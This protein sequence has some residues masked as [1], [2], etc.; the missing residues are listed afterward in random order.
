VKFVKLC[1]K[2]SEN[3]ENVSFIALDYSF[4]KMWKPNNFAVLGNSKNIFAALKKY[5][6]FH[7]VE[8]VSVPK[9]T[10]SETIL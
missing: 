7:S 1:G 6:V 5:F 10:E 9:C 8:A 3:D 4:F 2:S